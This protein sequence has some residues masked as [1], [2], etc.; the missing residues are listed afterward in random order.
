MASRSLRMTLEEL[1][2][3]AE[4]RA[5]LTGRL[6]K[7]VADGTL[8]SDVIAE[9]SGAVEY[10]V[11]EALAGLLGAKLVV[12][13]EEVQQGRFVLW[14]GSLSELN[15]VTAFKMAE[16]GMPDI[17]YHYNGLCDTVEVTLGLNEL[18]VLHE[19]G[20]AVRH[21][22]RMPCKV[23]NRALL[24]PLEAYSSASHTARAMALQGEILALPLEGVVL[25]LARGSKLSTL[26]ELASQQV[27]HVSLGELCNKALGFLPQQESFSKDSLFKLVLELRSRGYWAV[28]AI[29]LSIVRSWA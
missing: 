4:R 19:I 7:M 2:F 1:C 21:K 27:G 12:E 29:L 24:L 5:L 23:K 16:Q 18:T 9:V 8:Q 20:E 11:A 25:G 17:E 26:E 14:N 3:I 10:L 22:P 28:A 6:R 13:S 15:G